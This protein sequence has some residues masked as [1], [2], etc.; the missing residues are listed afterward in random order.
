MGTPIDAS[1][2]QAKLD[3]DQVN[4]SKIEK[5]VLRLRHRIFMAKVKGD[6]KGMESLQ[7]LLVSSW[8]AKLLAVRK[9]GQ[10]NSGRKTPGIDGAVST[11]DKD[12]MNLLKD[13]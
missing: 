2:A 12:R 9:V 7:R 3:W 6:L 8:A 4:W 11:S 1:G 5:V 13:G 10:E